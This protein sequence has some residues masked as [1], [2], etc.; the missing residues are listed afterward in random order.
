MKYDTFSPCLPHVDLR[1]ATLDHIGFRR[2]TSVPS[3]A[4]TLNSSEC[5]DKGPR[6]QRNLEHGLV[7]NLRF[8]APKLENSEVVTINKY[9]CVFCARFEFRTQK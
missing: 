3:L 1:W 8:R 4:I 6:L 2:L 5:V 7:L 9:E